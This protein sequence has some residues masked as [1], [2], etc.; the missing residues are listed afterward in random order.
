MFSCIEEFFVEKLNNVGVQ[1]A[2]ITYMLDHIQLPLTQLSKKTGYSA[3]YLTKTFQRYIGVG[4]K[5]FQRIQRFYES[6]CDLNHLTEGVDW[7]ELVFRHGYH[8]QAHFIKDFKSF[9]GYSPQNYLALAPSCP[10]YLYTTH[11]PNV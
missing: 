8:D 9:S 11:L 5:A 1:P 2:M 4:P 3:K 10:R 7:A 6:I